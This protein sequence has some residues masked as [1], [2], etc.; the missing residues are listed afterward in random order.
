MILRLA[1]PKKGFFRRIFHRRT[2]MTEASIATITGSAMMTER[3]D[4]DI[5]KL[6][7]MSELEKATLRTVIPSTRFA[8]L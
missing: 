2:K 6:T 3:A 1:A 8:V 7:T 5:E 4:S